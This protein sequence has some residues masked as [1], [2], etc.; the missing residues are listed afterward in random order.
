MRKKKKNNNS[1]NNNNNKMRRRRQIR[2]SVE[3]RHKD[4]R[5]YIF[6]YSRKN[7]PPIRA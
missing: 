2:L 6:T 5:Q 7:N 1:Y 4:K 3:P